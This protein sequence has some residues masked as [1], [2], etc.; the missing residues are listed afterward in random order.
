MKLS[1]RSL[2]PLM[3]DA[4]KLTLAALMG[5]MILTATA[6]TAT[7]QSAPATASDEAKA[8]TVDA[9]ITK[10]YAD[11]MITANQQ[12]NWDAVARTMRDNA[13]VMDQLI[14][15]KRAQSKNTM[16]A[17]DD[18]ETYEAF[19][20]AHLDGLKDLTA[21]FRVLYASMSDAQKK[22]ADAVFER[23]G[24]GNGDHQG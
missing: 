2:P 3:A 15:T 11:L 8:E 6:A 9:R 12:T 18:L 4:A 5:T 14:A 16:T 22:N 17:V 21:S 1:P 23:F 7:A 10:L 13:K 20:R 24:R 19:A